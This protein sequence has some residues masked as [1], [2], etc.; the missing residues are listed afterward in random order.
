M[1]TLADVGV[2]GLGVMGANLARNF[3]SRGLKVVGHDRSVALGRALAA[4]HP[5]A[6][7][8]DLPTFVASLARP[9]RIVLLVNAGAPVDA[10]LDGL[11]PLL[12]E[13]DVVVDGGNS[14]FMDTERRLARAD[15]R[16]WSFVG[17]GVSGGSEGALVGPSMMP[18]GD[19]AAWDVLRP[20]LEPAAAQGPYGRCVTWC[21]SGA[22]GHFVKMVHNGIEYG[23]M[24]LIA[25]TA[26]LLRH[27]L[28]LGPDEVADTFA[29]WNEG[30]LESY[31]VEITADVFRVRDPEHPDALLLDA[32]ADAAGQKGTGRWTVIAAAE[33]GVAI[34]TIASAVE[35]R[36]LSAARPV[37]ARAAQAYD[38]VRRPL[39]GVSPGEL[40][41][42][43][44]AS[45]IAS[46][47]QGFAMLDAASGQHGWGI[48][49][50]EIARVWT[51]GCIIRARFLGRV[52]DAFRVEPGPALLAL[53]PSFVEE[54]RKRLPSWRKVVS[55]AIASG[56]AVPG[57]AASLS[58]FDGLVTARGSA[59]VIQA[60][61][62]YFGSHGYERIDQPG[63]PQ[64]TDWKQL[65]RRN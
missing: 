9:R 37:R 42:A 62:D 21:G 26:T 25:E 34:P 55:S 46:Y 18:G 10:V 36:V 54:L 30:E 7:A 35:A 13:G 63:V 4:A 43:L 59:D 15:G 57:L 32:V 49:P 41:H 20:V 48:D 2:V 33:L 3:A 65:A 39:E 58:W 44:Y 1:S 16:P 8:E 17:M 14:L 23:D 53:E 27:G 45:K 51:A 64:H 5:V 40:A 28:K 11:D 19:R 61:R 29:R 52:M 31:L 38:P 6:F 24:Q 60:Q 12:E 56:I 47:T 22:A 50:A